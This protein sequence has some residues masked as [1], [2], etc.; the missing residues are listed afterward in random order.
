MTADNLVY[1]YIVG[2]YFINEVSNYYPN[3]LITYDLLTA[4]VRSKYYKDLKVLINKNVVSSL[5]SIKDENDRQGQPILDKL[6]KQSCRNT[7]N[8]LLLIQMFK[9]VNTFQQFFLKQLDDDAYNILVLPSLMYQLYFTLSQI[10]DK[11]TH[12]DLHTSNVLVYQLPTDKYINI[13]YHTNDKVIILKTKFIPKIIDYGRCFF[14]ESETLNSMNIRNKLCSVDECNQEDDCGNRHG[15]TFF[16]YN[17][18]TMKADSQDY[19][20][21]SSLRNMSHDLIFAN[22]VKMQYKPKKPNKVL[23]EILNKVY[24]KDQYGTPEVYSEQ[25]SRTKIYNV[26]D[27]KDELE[28]KIIGTPKYQELMTKAYSDMECMGTLHIYEKMTRK[29]EFIPDCE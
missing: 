20:I 13:K 6:I 9:N 10:Y 1:E 3:F 23:E 25:S 27:M 14:Y 28:E 18:D 7:T 2:K 24:Y 5:R 22:Y 12:Y 21:S 15:Y 8:Q 26:V 17:P 16:S 4:N 19:Y 29:M 11:F